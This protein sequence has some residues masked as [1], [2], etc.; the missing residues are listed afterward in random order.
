[1][2]VKMAIFLTTACLQFLFIW[3]S[4]S[5]SL[6]FRWYLVWRTVCLHDV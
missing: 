6:H 2:A 3:C 5:L 4:S 1:M